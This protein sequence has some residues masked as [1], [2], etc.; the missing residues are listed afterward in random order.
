MLAKTLPQT[1]VTAFQIKS[2]EEFKH[3]IAR[4]LSL[5]P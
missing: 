1:N 4:V 5:T 2:D 3:E